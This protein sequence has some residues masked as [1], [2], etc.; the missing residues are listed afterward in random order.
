M[1][2]ALIAVLIA[3]VPSFGLVAVAILQK[4]KAPQERQATAVDILQDVNSELRIEM[5]RL[6]Q[7]RLDAIQRSNE[8]SKELEREVGVLR[9]E[10]RVARQEARGAHET[11][12]RVVR[13]VEHLEAVLRQHGITFDPGPLA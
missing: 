4:R 5:A 10:L 1:S 8:R 13:R 9:E 7:D 2:E 12:G 11:T 3:I 6:S